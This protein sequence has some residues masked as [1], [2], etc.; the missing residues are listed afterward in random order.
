MIRRGHA[1]DAAW[2]RDTAA[3]VYA[4]LGDYRTII[5]TWLSHAGVLSFLDVDEHDTRQGFVLLGFYEPGS[6]TPVLARPGGSYVADLIAIGVAPEF[7]RR[8]VGKRL[9]GY[10]IDLATLAGGEVHVPEMRLTVAAT[11]ER[12]LTLFRAHG[13]E[14]L[15][16]LHGVYDR[17]QPAIRMHRKL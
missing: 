17:G 4:E 6:E 11:N 10:A 16:A 5:P 14:V 2:I 3:L 12:A 9:L 1:E 8:G 15:D 7:Q 13:F